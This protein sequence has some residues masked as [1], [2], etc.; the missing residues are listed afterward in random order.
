MATGERGGPNLF[1][2]V[3]RIPRDVLDK[4]RATA[5]GKA[6]TLTYEDFSM[7][8]LELGLEKESNQYLNA[9]RPGGGGSGSHGRGYQG[10]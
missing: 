10:P 2:L 6:R 4:C 1:W 3:A 7:L 9:Y 5:E 8:L